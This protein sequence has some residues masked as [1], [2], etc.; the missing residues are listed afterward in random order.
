MDGHETH[1]KLDTGAAVSIVSDKEPW[2][3]DH[4]LTKSQQILRGPGG[5][6]LSVV[7]TFRATL[8]YKQRQMSETVFV[9]KDQ[10]YSLLSKKACVD[11]GLIARIREV[12]TQPVNF[13]GEFPQLFHG[14]GKPKTKYHIKLNPDVKPVCLYTPRKVP[15]PLLP[16]VKNRIDSMTRQ[17]VISP[18]TV[19]TEWCSGIVPVPKPNVRVRICVDLAPLYKAVQRETH[20]MGSVDEIL[21]ML[22]ESRVF[23]KLDASSGFW[24]IPLDEDSKLLTTFVTPFG[25]FYFNRLPFGISSAPEIFQRTMSDILEGLDGVICRMDDILIHGRNHMEHDARVRAVLFRRQR[26]GLTLNIQKCEFSQGRLEFL[27]HI[28]DAQGVHA[29]PE[30]THA[31]GHFPTS[32]TVTELQRCMGMVNQLGKFVPGLADISAPLRQLL[33]KDSAWYWDEAQQTAFQQVKEQFASPEVL[34]HYNPNR[35]TVWLGAVLLQTQDNGQRRPICYISRSLSD[36]E[37]NYA[38][39]EKEPLASTW[40]SKRLEEYVLGLR[41]TMETDHKSL[42]P[43]LTTTDL[44]KMHPRI[45]RFRLRMMR[46]NPEVLHVPG[47]CQIS[48]DALSRAPVN[49]PNTSDVQFIEEVETFACSTVDQLPATAQRL[50]EIIEAQRNDEVCMEVRGYCQAGWPAYM[51]HQPLLRPYWESRAHLAVVDD[52]L[53]YDERIVIPQALRLD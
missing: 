28:V 4:Q 5:T 9:L 33:R 46:Y 37:R 36:A 19:P 15:H 39:I 41:F 14:L 50:Q 35:E 51:L 25:R 23:T 27:G 44:S 16:K 31:I 43:L 42:V 11:P 21:A 3:K 32:T 26:A 6:I 7:D 17:G 2:L 29:D 24:Q 18:V 1:F 53:L 38:I 47:K 30:K 34:A 49:S 13:I 12:N 48:A 40:A 45:L 8:A 52:L 22:G 20:A 10:L